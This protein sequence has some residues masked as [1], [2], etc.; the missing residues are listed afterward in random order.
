MTSLIVIKILTNVMMKILSEVQMKL[1]F[2]FLP[3][4]FLLTDVMVT[5]RC[6]YLICVD[7]L[8]IRSY[9]RYKLSVLTF[10]LLRCAGVEY[11]HCYIEEKYLKCYCICMNAL[12]IYR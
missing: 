7:L 12:T 8:V 2:Y 3:F 5:L 6:S 1:L 10:D 9:I 4:L 11:V